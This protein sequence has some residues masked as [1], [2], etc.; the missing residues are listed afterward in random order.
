MPKTPIG[1]IYLT[2]DFVV[3]GVHSHP[4]KHLFFSGC[5]LYTPLEILGKNPLLCFETLQNFQVF[6]LGCNGM[7]SSMAVAPCLEDPKDQPTKTGQ[8]IAVPVCGGSGS[9]E[10]PNKGTEDPDYKGYMAGKSGIF[11]T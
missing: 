9:W 11:F 8:P 1:A 3:Y 7:Y 4:H 5:F 2:E 6:G 10:S